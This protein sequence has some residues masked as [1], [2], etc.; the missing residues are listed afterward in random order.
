MSFK[1][2]DLNNE[3]V[4]VVNEP[5][6]LKSKVVVSNEIKRPSYDTPLKQLSQDE[7][8]SVK[9]DECWKRLR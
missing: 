7:S 8:V 1:R 4:L 2:I 5:P 3:E 6:V 9:S